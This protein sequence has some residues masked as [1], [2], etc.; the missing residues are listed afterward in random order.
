MPR[1]LIQL[2]DRPLGVH[3]FFAWLMLLGLMST[4]L[5]LGSRP[6]AGGIFPPPWDKLVHL[7]FFGGIAVLAYIGLG[8][9]RP[10]L[11]ILLVGAFGMIDEV[12]QSLSPTR[13][14]SVADWAMDVLG[15]CLAML[16]VKLMVR[17]VSRRLFG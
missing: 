2:L 15:A 14:A 16:V 12:A 7:L 10:L 3:R 11:T 5:Y 17:G 9:R 6:G 8:G 4:L 1:L 13:V